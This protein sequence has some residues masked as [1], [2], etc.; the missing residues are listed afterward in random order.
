[1]QPNLF[2]TKLTPLGE[3]GVAVQLEIGSAVEMAFLIKMIKDRDVNSDELLQS[4]HL[5]EVEH[6]PLSSSKRQV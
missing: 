2:G 5:S 4:S 6:S 3:S 1:M